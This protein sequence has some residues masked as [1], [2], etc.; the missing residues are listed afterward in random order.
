MQVIITL[1][2]RGK[3]FSEK[4]FREPKPLIS[5][6][7]RPAIS[8]LIQSFPH[9]WKLIFVLAEQDRQAGIESLIL[10]LSPNAK[11]V[12]TP[13]SERGP[14]DTVLAG[15][16]SLN[17]DEGVLVSY[18]DLAP[19]WKS[20]LFEKAVSVSN[21]DMASVN[22]Q[23]F[24]PTYLGP[25]TYC[26]LQSNGHGWVTK[27]QENVLFTHQIE[28]EITAAGIFYFKDKAL[29]EEALLEQQRQNLTYQ[30]EFYISQSLQAMLNKNP[31]IKILDYRIEH[32]IQLGTPADIERFEFWFNYINLSQKPKAFSYID[33][34]HQPDEKE[35]EKF[36]KEKQYWYTILINFDL[37]QF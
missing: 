32:F 23:G 17:S 33:S 11:V 1:A 4:G 35:L 6:C 27:L 20:H 36:A 34:K 29:L 7:G 31:N 18:G 10:K 14:I 30:N 15:I 21:C 19:V 8:Y 25:D 26:H 5:A 3:R 22:F 9:T 12:Y 28:K 2:G 24:H 37:I 13:F 16:P